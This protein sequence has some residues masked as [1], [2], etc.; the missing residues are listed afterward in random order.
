MHIACADLAQLETIMNFQRRLRTL[1]SC[2]ALVLAAGAATAAPAAGDRAPDRLGK[3]PNGETV[4][5]SNYAGRVLVIA[6]WQAECPH[7]MK[8]LP[9]LESLQKVAKNRVQ[10]IAINVGTLS[11]F[12]EA[13]REMGKVKMM[14]THDTAERGVMAYGVTTLPHLAV[15]GRDGKIVEVHRGY[16]EADL[17]EIINDVNVAVS[18]S[19]PVASSAN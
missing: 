10:V 1:F 8:Q 3:L 13:V 4:K 11:E 14:V 12:K 6:F 2:L 17:A 18:A 15:I 9:M 19:A 16:T 5:L 7:C